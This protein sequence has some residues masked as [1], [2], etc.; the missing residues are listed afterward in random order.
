MAGWWRWFVKPFVV[1]ADGQA[2]V[3]IQWVLAVVV[4]LIALMIANILF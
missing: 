3:G 4:F 2:P 1:C